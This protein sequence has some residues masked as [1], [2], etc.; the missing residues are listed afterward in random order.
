MNLVKPLLPLL[1]LR[2]RDGYDLQPFQVS[3]CQR[4][5]VP[6]RTTQARPCLASSCNTTLWWQE[7][8][9]GNKIWGIVVHAGNFSLRHEGLQE[10][11]GK[12]RDNTASGTDSLSSITVPGLCVCIRAS[13]HFQSLSLAVGLP[14]P[15]LLPSHPNPLQGSSIMYWLTF[16]P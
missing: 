11:T 15:P 1:D 2:L 8:G 4:L 10:H 3:C 7:R 12:F 6:L 14:S 9:C 16:T 5:C 13:A